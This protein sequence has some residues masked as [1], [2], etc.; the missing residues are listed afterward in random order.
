MKQRLRTIYKKLYACFGP[1]NWW[2]AKT[3]FEVIAGAILTQNTSWSN[4][5]LAI[6]NLKKEKLLSVPSLSKAAPS[7]IA[8]L[9]RPAGYY[10]IKTGRLISFLKFFLSNY[11]GSIRRMSLQDTQK[12][13]SELLSV[14]G[15][16]QE[17]AD[18]I[19]LYALSKP[20]FVV[21]AYTK[22]ILLRHRFISNGADYKEIQKLFMENL[23]N[24]AGL[25]NEYHALLV[26][27]GKKFCLKNNPRCAAC[28]LKE[29]LPPDL[30]R[31]F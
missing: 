5:E 21:D 26:R 19:L 29:S 16:G 17:T 22:R 25:F 11:A 13:R 27:A 9:I 7:R 2:P 3:P 1:Q 28:P 4:V 30:S 31:A 12:L 10:N 20:V 24:D 6:R 14:N 18:S 15:I 23:K 8:R